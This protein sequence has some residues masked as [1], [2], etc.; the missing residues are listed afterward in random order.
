M[1][2]D[3]EIIE[4]LI[5]G[6]LIGAALGLLISKNK[7]EGTILGALAGA[8]IVATFRANEKAN[9]TKIPMVVEENGNLYQIHED[10]KKTLIRKINKSLEKLPQNFKL[11]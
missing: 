2:N 11:K 6:G 4:S 1:K 5:S 3:E 8:A 7:E 9:E 10:G